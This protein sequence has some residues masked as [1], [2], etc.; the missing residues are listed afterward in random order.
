MFKTSNDTF[1]IIDNFA[2]SDVSYIPRDQKQAK[3]KNVIRN[4]NP[5]TTKSPSAVILFRGA[6]PF[7]EAASKSFV[8][9]NFSSITLEV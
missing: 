2:K 6:G 3:N 8:E 9:I 7:S 5:A 1:R 4:L